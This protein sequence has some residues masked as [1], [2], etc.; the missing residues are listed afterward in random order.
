MNIKFFT[1]MI[2]LIIALVCVLALCSCA[3]TETGVTSG[4][5]SEDD[6]DH[7]H[8]TEK[9]TELKENEILY[10]LSDDKT[11]YYVSTVNMYQEGE[12]VIRS[13]YNTLPV[14]KIGDAAFIPAMDK[15]TRITIPDSIT[16]IGN[17][18]FRGCSALTYF[19]LPVGLE[20]IGD[21][22]FYGCTAL[23]QIRI[24]ATISSIGKDILKDCNMLKEIVVQPGNSRYFG[25]NNCLIDAEYKTLLKGCQ[26]SV[27]P[28]TGIV[29]TIDDSAFLAC[30]GLT[31][32][33]I[34]SAVTSIGNYAFLACRDL[35]EIKYEGT[36]ADWENVS[37]GE[38]WA[39]NTK[40]QKVI[41]SDGEVAISE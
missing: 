1:K 41:C 5:S 22:A 35:A 3:K 16:E 19:D 23:E 17:D 25:V 26:A 11:Y 9:P 40:A 15:L 38:D 31:T 21:Y 20:K 32:I 4:S 14:K 6:H 30:Q 39:T 27:I 34:P 28:A 12:L 24:P 13:T 8:D 36:V 18:A 33:T 29:Q 37:K 2:A 7:D 10:A